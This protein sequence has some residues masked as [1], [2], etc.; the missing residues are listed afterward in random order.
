MLEPGVLMCLRFTAVAL[1][2]GPLNLNRFKLT[3]RKNAALHTVT[4]AS[5]PPTQTTKGQESRP[6][7]ASIAPLDGNL[8]VPFPTQCIVDVK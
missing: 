8:M 4:A 5:S 3:A 7:S 2:P 1:R 6:L